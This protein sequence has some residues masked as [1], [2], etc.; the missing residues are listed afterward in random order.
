MSTIQRRQVYAI[1]PL[2]A[3]VECAFCGDCTWW[4]KRPSLIYRGSHRYARWCCESC[5]RTSERVR[6]YAEAAQKTK[7]ALASGPGS[8]AWREYQNLDTYM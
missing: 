6:T 2:R 3:Q 5:G 1:Q 7:A 8:P 4:A